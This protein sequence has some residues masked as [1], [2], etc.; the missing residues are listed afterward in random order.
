MLAKLIAYV[1]G[2]ADRRRTAAEVDDELQSH[3]DMETNAN[4]GRGMSPAEARRVALHDLGGS[5]QTR[6][7]VR[8]LRRRWPDAM[9]Q[10][11]QYTLRRLMREPGFVGTAVLILAVGIGAC[12][13]MFSI[14]QAVLLR[15]LAVDAPDRLVMVWTRS[16]Q[17]SAVGELS[18][19]DVPRPARRYTVV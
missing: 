1:R 19:Q 11:V 17:H 2:L 9:R 10:D 12:T 13:A 8:A 5:T 7:A 4:A 14:V 6:E 18:V 15:P 3:V 16:T